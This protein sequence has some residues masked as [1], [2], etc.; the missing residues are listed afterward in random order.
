MLLLALQEQCCNRVRADALRPPAALACDARL[1][2]ARQPGRKP[3]RVQLVEVPSPAAARVEAPPRL[4]APPFV[5]TVR[6]CSASRPRRRR[7]P[8]R[9]VLINA[10]PRL[11]RRVASRLAHRR[12][13]AGAYSPGDGP[14]RSEATADASPRY[15]THCLTQTTILP[16]KLCAAV[17]FPVPCNALRTL[18]ENRPTRVLRTTKLF[19]SD[20]RYKRLSESSDMVVRSTRCEIGFNPFDAIALACRNPRVK[21]QPAAFLKQQ[22]S[23]YELVSCLEVKETKGTRERGSAGARREQ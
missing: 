18:R 20:R 2:L 14:G 13:V 3:P 5:A 1:D 10:L 17:T 11:S 15:A 12:G 4:L 7:I 8:K 23:T 9:S 19:D 22:P 6:F 16:T 21:T